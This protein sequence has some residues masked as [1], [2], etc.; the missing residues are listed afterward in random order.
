MQK[1]HI[2][3]IV[4]ASVVVV[5]AIVAS[6]V[7]AWHREGHR[8]FN[9]FGGYFGQQQQQQQFEGRE[10]GF[11]FGHR[12]GQGSFGQIGQMQGSEISPETKQ[13]FEDLRTARESGDAAKIK[14]VT[15][16][17]T[18]ARNAE[19]A[20]KEADLEKALAG[21]YEAWKTYATAQKMPQT[22]MDKITADN[23]ADFVALDAAKKQV[24][25][26]E[27]K[28]GLQGGYG[29]FSMPPSPSP[30]AAPLGK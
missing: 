26:L 25:D 8:G 23:F 16:K 6:C 28:L 12:S 10:S 9:K 13:L 1:K 3:M 21:G 22:E 15:D 27:Q 14:E 2:I 5:A 7:F 17:I 4:V 11:G 19:M 20:A 18:A 30:M 29:S 24:H